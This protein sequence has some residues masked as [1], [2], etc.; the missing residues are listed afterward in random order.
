LLSGCSNSSRHSDAR[1]HRLTPR[2]RKRLLRKTPASNPAEEGSG[3]TETVS[4]IDASGFSGRRLLDVF[5]RPAGSRLTRSKPGRVPRMMCR[6]PRSF[7]SL[8][9]ASPPPSS[10]TVPVHHDSGRIDVCMLLLIVRRSRLLTI[11]PSYGPTAIGIF[12][13]SVPPI[14]CVERL[15]NS[16]LPIEHDPV[17]NHDHADVLLPDHVQG[18]SLSP[19][20]SGP[21]DRPCSQ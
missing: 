16:V 11:A 8:R 17:R 5:C 3:A 20:V 7:A 15:V 6:L 21:A 19:L 10:L 4:L 14:F 1:G 13:V 9:A 2:I 18:V 12:L